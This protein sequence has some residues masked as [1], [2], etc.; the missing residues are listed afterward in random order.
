MALPRKG[1]LIRLAIYVPLIGFFGWQ[2]INRFLEDR[3]QDATIDA[4]QRKLDA[5]PPEKFQSFTLPDGTV[6][7]VPVLT[8]EEAEEIYG[9]EVPDKTQAA[10]PSAAA[11]TDS[12]LA[13]GP[14]QETSTPHEE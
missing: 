7:K 9:I 6:K 2:A 11:P 5:L 4:Q 3:G 10:P 8:P 14:G 13:P 1:I 12:P